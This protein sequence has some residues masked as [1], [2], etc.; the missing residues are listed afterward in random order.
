MHELISDVIVIND[1]GKR[2]VQ[3][4]ELV[5]KM[6]MLNM[7]LSLK[8]IHKMV[9]EEL[10]QKI[11]EKLLER[12]YIKVTECYDAEYAAHR[13]RAELEVNV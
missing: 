8:E 13:F 7:D 11:C 10:A 2:K 5:S 1:R 9:S 4:E 12:G 3:V 6:D